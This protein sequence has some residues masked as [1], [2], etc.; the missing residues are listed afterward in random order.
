MMKKR[1]IVI[2]DIHGISFMI[3]RIL[4]KL[5]YNANNDKLVFLGDYINRG[6]TNKKTLDM[7]IDL[8]KK[9]KEVIT[10]K[11]NHD[12]FLLDFLNNTTDL[13]QEMLEKKYYI[14]YYKI[15]FKQTLQEYYP[16]KHIF[17]NLEYIRDNFKKDYPDT[18][19]FLN[20][21][22]LFHE[23]KKYL[24]VHAGISPET[25]N[26]NN[27]PKEE[28]YKMDRM[29]YLNTPHTYPKKIVSGHT[30]AL[31]AKKMMGLSDIDATPYI[32]ENKILLDTGAIFGYGLYALTIEN[33][34]GEY[35]VHNIG[36]SDSLPEDF[37]LENGQLREKLLEIHTDVIKILLDTYNYSLNMAVA[38]LDTAIENYFSEL[39]VVLY[40]PSGDHLYKEQLLGRMLNFAQK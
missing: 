10:L 25:Q 30:P 36:F 37:F 6:N 21:L 13:N 12:A 16:D 18:Y 5:V 9:N 22:D 26:L 19:N 15:N 20:R 38:L 32:G 31:T 35:K 2:P 4:N 24:Y 34:T 39:F 29:V 27:L 8:K 28:F 14:P 11:G 40:E 23:D 33:D 7:L 3:S 17:S 1:T